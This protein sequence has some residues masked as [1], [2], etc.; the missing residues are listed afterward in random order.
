M[1][2]I[3]KSK[4]RNVRTQKGHIYVKMSDHY[5]ATVRNLSEFVHLLNDDNESKS[6]LEVVDISGVSIVFHTAVLDLIAQYKNRAPESTQPM[7]GGYVVKLMRLYEKESE[8]SRRLGMA[9]KYGYGLEDYTDLSWLSK[10]QMRV[11]S[12]LRTQIKVE[13]I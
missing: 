9:N 5:T 12:Y 13:E 1:H 6:E 3:L 11:V 10:K 7:N 8:I 4:H 2:V